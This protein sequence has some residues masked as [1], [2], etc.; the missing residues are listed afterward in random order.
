M[1]PFRNPQTVGQVAENQAWLDRIMQLPVADRSV[2]WVFSADADLSAW[3]GWPAPDMDDILRMERNRLDA[4]LRERRPRDQI[5][6]ENQPKLMK[7][8]PALKIDEIKPG[9]IA[10]DIQLPPFK[11]EYDTHEQINQKLIQTV[12]L[13]KDR[14]FYVRNTIDLGKVG[15]AL[16]LTGPEDIPGTWTVM[17]NEV[18]DCRGIAPGYYNHRGVAYW[19]YRIPERQNSQGMSARNMA[20][21][22]AGSTHAGQVGHNFLLQALNTVQ[23]IK[24][25]DNLE[26]VLT[27][28]G[29]SSMRLNNNIALYLTQK[30]GAPVGVEYCGRQLGLIVNGA[31]K[32]MDENDLRP[33]WIHKDLHKVGLVMGA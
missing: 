7:S 1:R 24:F 5:E 8:Y 33:S 19:V 30:K 21:K 28:G 18:K 6:I 15:F 23:D 3:D 20:A 26:A 13:I 22:S 10:R 9:I 25:A 31:V 14:P 29:G 12:I 17:Y 32:V 16:V 11:I 2:D 4:R 27:A